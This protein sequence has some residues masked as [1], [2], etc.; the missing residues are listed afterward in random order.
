MSFQKI[1][2]IIDMSDSRYVQNC[3]VL[4]LNGMKIASF[5]D[6]ISHTIVATE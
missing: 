2:C 6:V 4:E 3:T 1:G 5:R